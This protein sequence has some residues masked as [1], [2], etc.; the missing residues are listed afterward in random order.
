MMR[1]TAF[2]AIALL[3]ITAAWPGAA[4]AW[5]TDEPAATVASRGPGAGQEQEGQA[6]SEEAEGATA[7]A[8]Q[9]VAAAKDEA[10]P[11]KPGPKLYFDEGLWFEFPRLRWRMRIGGELH[12]DVAGFAAPGDLRPL[13]T[14]ADWRRARIDLR[15][16]IAKRVRY[17][18]RWDAVGNPPHLKDAYLDIHFLR[19]NTYIR[20]G[21]F[22]AVFGLESGASSNDFFFMEPSLAKVFVPP[23]ET[24]FLLHSEGVE[25]NWDVG[26]AG[27]SN[28]LASCQVCNVSG[29]LGRFSRGF[30][31]GR[32]DHLVHG[33]VNWARR[34]TTD[35]DITQFRTRPESFLSPFLVDTG[36]IPSER[37]DV[38]VAEVAYQNGPL[39]LQAEYT[40]AWLKAP[41]AND[42]HFDGY[43][44][45]AAVT[46]TGETRRYSHSDGSFGRPIPDRPVLGGGLG[47]VEVAV[48]YSF[49]DLNDARISGG[50]I[51]DFTL[52]VNWFLRHRQR[53]NFNVIRADRRG[54]DD[55]WIF[56][57]RLQWSI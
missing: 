27:A 24:G 11:D 48:R 9:S 45:M 30:T 51:E 15:G 5:S 42:P 16:F 44:L 19:L 50:V 49:L 18:L 39:V 34:W 10:A 35:K 6:Q 41:K 8:A 17:R 37:V 28:E 12:A 14:R 4:M 46:L 21:R 43:Y 32:E 53:L 13:D 20:S 29:F 7:D 22:S 2:L 26:F 47:A 36:L 52:G 40:G 3:L 31:L 57:A 33:G 55:L 23:Q 38:G 25:G 54:F 1:W 56:Q